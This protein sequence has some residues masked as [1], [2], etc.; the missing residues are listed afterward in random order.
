M[1]S[2]RKD[3]DVIENDIICI[4]GWFEKKCARGEPLSVLQCSNDT[5]VSRTTVRDYIDA[6]NK[7]K[8]GE[9]DTWW[10]ETVGMKY[11]YDV[12]YIGRPDCKIWVTKIK[13]KEDDPEDLIVSGEDYQ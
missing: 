7:Y 5:G 11:H 10:M 6:Y 12:K 3:W 2:I 13:L 4:L 9:Y 8:T 1:S